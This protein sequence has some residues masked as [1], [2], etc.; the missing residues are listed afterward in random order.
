MKNLSFQNKICESFYAKNLK[1]ALISIDKLR[2]LGELRFDLSTLN[3]DS[4]KSIFDKSDKTL[5]FTYRKTQ[6]QEYDRL[7]TY[8]Q[9]IKI[10]YAFIDL[11]IYIDE[12]LIKEL[13]PLLLSSST[14][15]IVSYHNY[16]NTPS[17]SELKKVL[18]L[19]DQYHPDIYKIATH[20]EKEKDI[21]ILLQVQ[22]LKETS[23]CFGMGELATKSRIKSLLNGALF[24]YAALDISQSTAP[25]QVDIHLLKQEYEKQAQDKNIRLAVLGN[26]IHH[27]KSPAIFQYLFKIFHIDGIYEKLELSDSKEFLSVSKDYQ[28][29]NVTAPYKQSIIK[30]ID[31]LS[32]AAKSIGAVNALYKDNQD[33]I[34]DNTDYLGI[35]KSIETSSDFFNHTNGK[36]LIIGA[37]GAARAAV[38]A[39]NQKGIKPDVC[40]RTYPK[41]QELATK[42]DARAIQKD[43]ILLDHY[44]LIINT[45]PKAF[46]II[47]K[48]NLRQDHIVL[49]AIYPESLFEELSIKIGFRFIEGEKWL[50]HQAQAFFD[51]LI[52]NNR[53]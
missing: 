30:Y 29:F 8:Q 38:Y 1:E 3:A 34:G 7:S 9:A 20:L 40:N 16:K 26:P 13:K 48:T 44:Q 27:S 42:F 14:K 4:L 22:A 46:D 11:D 49:D 10:G 47:K 23:I 12:E 28:G 5:I 41:T 2:S 45:I 37:G 43:Q 21:D 17:F 18:T 24:S 36:C 19:M 51:I 32:P 52:R 39:M 25:G 53:K 31:K 50:W 33:W 15:L 6:A 35:I